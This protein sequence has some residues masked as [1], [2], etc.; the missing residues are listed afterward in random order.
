MERIEAETPLS[1]RARAA[2]ASAD[3]TTPVISF[4]G[5]ALAY[6][7]RVLWR[8]LDLDVRP[9][10]FLAV[11]GPNG[12]G[13]TSLLR[14]LLGRRRLTSGT[15][16]VLGGAPRRG[17]RHMGYVPQQKT[18]PAHTMLRAR[19]LVQL[20]L[21]GHRWGLSPAG[22]SVH[23]RV[24]DLLASVGAT[25]FADV[26]VGRLSGGEQ[27]RVRIA[28]ALATDPRIMLL[29]EPLLSL[30]LQY[31]RTVTALVD[32]RRR[33]AGTAVVFVTHEINP[34]LK[35]VDRVLYLAQGRFRIGP[36]DEVMTTSALTELYGTQV[37]VVRVRDRIVVIGAPDTATVH[38]HAEAP[39]G[40]GRP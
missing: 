33:S 17:S 20:G 11:L 25:P 12:S 10:E 23:R 8:D 30:D 32:R 15:V 9:G 26:P 34:V 40:G 5:A 14:V 3:P 28:Q 2:R 36:P 27:Q 19:D 24:D 29:D 16:A 13:K 38:D 35:P 39:D 1:G 37:D 31:Q 21:D 7:D 22:R 6:G 18:L 4:R